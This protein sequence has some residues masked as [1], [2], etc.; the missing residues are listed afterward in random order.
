MM[1]STLR[2]GFSDEIGSWKIIFIRVR[3]RAEVVARQLRHVLALEHHPPDCSARGNCMI[4]LPVVDL[5]QPDSP[6]S[7]RVSPSF[8]SRL[9][10]DTACTLQPG[11]TDRK[12]DD[13]IL[14]AQQR[15]AFRPQMRVATAGHLCGSLAAPSLAPLRPHSYT[16]PVDRTSPTRRTGN[17]VAV[18]PTARLRS[19]A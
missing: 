18:S 10:S 16:T 12:L 2:R 7:P 6:T 14:D 13:E 15:V 9:T 8:T 1:S 11:T 5:P 4:A 19:N 17:P 3:V